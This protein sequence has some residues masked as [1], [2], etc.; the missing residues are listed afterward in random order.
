LNFQLFQLG[1][2]LQSVL[3]NGRS[4]HSG[5]ERD[6]DMLRSSHVLLPPRDRSMERSGLVRYMFRMLV[7]IDESGDPGF[8]V[9][10][11]SSTHFVLTMVI[12][13]TMD[14]ARD[15]ETAIEDL[16]REIGVK[17]EFKF[18]KLRAD[19]RDI[20]FHRITP[21]AFTTRSLVLDKSLIRSEHL[22]SSKETF[23]NFFLRM[24]MKSAASR[25]I[26]AK[27]VID[28]SG[29]RAFRQALSSYLR[30]H[31]DKQAVRKVDLRDSRKDRLLQLADLGRLRRGVGGRRGLRGD[32]GRR[33]RLRGGGGSPAS[34]AGGQDGAGRP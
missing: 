26:D 33:R 32:P 8:K 23:Y 14:A 5:A 12:F 17:P 25:W 27:V 15:A 29:E 30:R 21:L 10:K 16:A 7:F 28:G 4:D 34:D 3:Q 6:P 9:A 11:G 13:E 31:M 20:F 22:T 18:G 1:G 2:V 24:V 19:R